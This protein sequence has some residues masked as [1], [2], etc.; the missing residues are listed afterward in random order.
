MHTKC[1]ARKLRL[2]IVLYVNMPKINCPV[3]DVWTFNCPGEAIPPREDHPL[4]S[5]CSFKHCEGLYKH[6]VRG[7]LSTSEIS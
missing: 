7:Y 6:Q 3:S 5:V 4:N 2:Q 1:P